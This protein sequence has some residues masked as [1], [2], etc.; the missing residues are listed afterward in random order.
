MARG[1]RFAACLMS[2]VL[3][4]ALLALSS[5]TALAETTRQQRDSVRIQ[6]DGGFTA[7]NGVRSGTGTAR[8]P[9]V[10]SGWDIPTL[11]IADTNAYVRIEDNRISR[12]ILN[13]NGDRVTV[14][15][16]DVGDMRVN[17]NV[18]RT[19]DPTGGRIYSNRFSSISQIRHFDGIFEKNLVGSA[20]SMSLPFLNDA[21]VNFDGFNGARFRDNTIYGAVRVQLHG[22]HHSS[23]YEDASHHHGAPNDPPA[24]HGE[25]SD[26]DHTIRYHQVTISGNKIYSNGYYALG[27][28]DQN[29]QAND[30]TANS[31]ENEELNDP[32]VHYTKVRLA[33][34]RLIGAGLDVDIFNAKDQRH[35]G[36]GQGE[37]QIVG[38]TVTIERE[39]SKTIEPLHGISIREAQGVHVMI[40][41]NAVTRTVQDFD[42]MGREFSGD[43]GISLWG[44]NAASVHLHENTVVGMPYGVFASDFTDSVDWW[45]D[46]LT[47]RDVGEAVYYDQSVKNPPKDGN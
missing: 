7:S 30:R 41:G 37:L 32:H 26:V 22:H 8:D 34:N 44:L 3:G 5:P 29:H 24:E 25:M 39:A 20:G 6:D 18:P 27:Y 16:N 4:A 2:L 11:S 21:I 1:K 47:T 45:I 12:L 13:W 17:E 19:G 28:T 43:A 35:R 14:T 23:S 46:A 36:I 10:I 31:E 15:R 38:N 33:N 9:Y 42:L 40:A